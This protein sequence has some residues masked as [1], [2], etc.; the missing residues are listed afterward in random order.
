[1]GH[2][3]ALSETSSH[4]E[5]SVLTSLGLSPCHSPLTGDTQVNEAKVAG[6]VSAAQITA[7]SREIASNESLSHMQN[8]YEQR[9]A[10][11]KAQLLARETECEGL[12]TECDALNDELTST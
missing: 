8:R 5:C 9:L 10:E 2:D 11:M 1:M 12:R 4:S 6:D 7:Q 3:E